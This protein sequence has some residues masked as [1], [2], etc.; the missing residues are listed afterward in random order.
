M[1]SRSVSQCRG[2]RRALLAV[3]ILGTGAA[4][5]AMTVHYQCVG[6]R[7][8]SAELSPRDGQIHFEGH[9]WAITRVRDAREARYVNARAGV[10]VVTREREM[11]FTHG[12]ETLQCFLKSDAL[13]P[14]ETASPPSR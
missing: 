13:Q 11:R 9:D 12:G 4:A 10:T 3:A 8:L 14:F 6:Y 2:V 7:P 1:T 5:P